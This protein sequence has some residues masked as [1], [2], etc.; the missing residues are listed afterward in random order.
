MN[1]VQP[2]K[3]LKARLGKLWGLMPL[4]I[5]G[6]LVISFM[7]FTSSPGMDG[8]VLKSSQAYTIPSDDNYFLDHVYFRGFDTAVDT[9]QGDIFRF[10]LVGTDE[11]GYWASSGVVKGGYISKIIIEAT[12]NSVFFTNKGYTNNQTNY[13]TKLNITIWIENPSNVKTYYYPLTQGTIK[14][15]LPTSGYYEIDLGANDY[16]FSAAGTYEFGYE[17]KYYY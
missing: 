11:G 6:V 12:H 8:I 16:V 2:K 1:H 5:I 13:E 4:T 10:D 17:V 14:D 15:W 7:L 9:V 3:P